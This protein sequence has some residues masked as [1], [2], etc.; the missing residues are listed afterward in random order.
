LLLVL[1]TAFSLSDERRH[2]GLLD[3]L[4]GLPSRTLILDRIEQALGRAR[5]ENTSLAVML[6]DLDRFK[7]V[8]DTY[9]HAVGDLLL[10]AVSARLAGALRETDTIGRLG[11]DEFVVLAEGS[12]L[13]MGPEV[14]AERIRAALT[15]PFDL[16]G[17][18]QITLSVHASIGIAEGERGSAADLL[19]DADLALYEAKAA[20]KDCY[21]LFGSQMQRAVQSRLDLETDL[22]RAVG[23]DQLFLV[24]QPAVDLRTEEITGV[25]AL[26]RWNH[27]TRGLLMPGAFI[28]VAEES[29]LIVPIGRWVLGEACRQA[30]SWQ[31]QGREL[32]MAV[33]VSGRQ[34]DD[35]CD[36]PGDVTAA[37]AN[38]GLEPKR[39]TLDVTET[40]LMRDA[41]SSARRLRALKGLGLRVAIDDFGTGH[42]ILSH[43]QQLSVD[44]LKI[45]RSIISGIAS[46]PEADAL[47]RAFVQMGKS[48]GLENYAKG[49]EDLSQLR[50]LQDAQCDSGNGYLFARPLSVAAF[51]ALITSAV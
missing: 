48:L 15:Q 40:T 3:S 42:S 28:A 30:A 35:S 29:G 19:R 21:V 43:L 51:E 14:M 46:S 1:A 26:L 50:N 37:L 11:G 7:D 8:N 27:P 6:L 32:S 31:E 13:A 10:R 20:G 16:D 33:N 49:I 25:E 22:R 12:S 4:T 23:T 18:A 39:L 34:L 36:L 45:D 17:P 5:R 24:Y 47:I 38:S 44:T 9:G 41:A 2:R